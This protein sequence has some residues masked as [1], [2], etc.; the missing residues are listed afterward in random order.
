[1][2]PKVRI[3]PQMI[4]QAAFEIVRSEGAEA[5]NARRIAQKLNCSTQPVL[6]SFKTVDEIRLEVYRIA[7]EFHTNYIMPDMEPPDMT[8]Q[9]EPGTET[10]GEADG[11][12]QGG[13]GFPA[14]EDMTSPLLELGLNYI[15]FGHEEKHLFRFLFQTNMLGSNV[16]SLFDSPALS[17]LIGIVAMSTGQDEA[18]ARK[19]FMTFFSC[20]H[21]YAS[22]LA[23][24]AMNYDEKLLESSLDIV[25]SCCT[26]QIGG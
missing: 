21:G 3:T 15:R 7:D 13:Q 5:L 19:S 12:Q 25:F 14:G 4:V 26:G 22:L 1:M 11:A 16:Q 2:P 10:G 6:Y 24:N 23:N 17:E 8:A 9:T 20:V 18:T